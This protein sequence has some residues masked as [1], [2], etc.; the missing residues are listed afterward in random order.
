MRFEVAEVDAEV[1][2]DGTFGIVGREL[3]IARE[4]AYALLVSDTGAPSYIGGCRRC[5]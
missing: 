3:R 4:G 1:V 2:V 5:R